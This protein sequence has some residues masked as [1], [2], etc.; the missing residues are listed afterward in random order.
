M[1]NIDFE[2]YKFGNSEVLIESIEKIDY[3]ENISTINWLSKYLDGINIV[4]SDGIFQNTVKSE[5]SILILI[6]NIVREISKVSIIGNEIK[7]EKYLSTINMKY[8]IVD[9]IDQMCDEFVRA[10]QEL[11]KM[12]EDI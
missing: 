2:L 12:R 9:G 4:I 7:N 8:C 11:L 3:T 5:N 10:L 6:N 1:L